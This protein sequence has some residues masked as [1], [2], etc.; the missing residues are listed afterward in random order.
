MK[1]I[2]RKS[3]AAVIVI[4]VAGGPVLASDALDW[5]PAKT[6][7]FAVGL[8]QWERTD[9]WSPFP[10]AMIDRR[11]EQLVA[12]F[13]DAGVDHE[14]IS[15][16]QDAEAAKSRIE[17][18]FIELLDETDEDDLLV[19]YFCGHGYRDRETGSTWFACY[20]AADKSSSGWSVRRIFSTIEAHFNGRRVLLLADCCHSGALYDEARRRGPDSDIAYAVLTSSYAHNTST[21]NWTFSDCVLAGLRGEGQVDLDGDETVDLQEI[22]RYGELEL[23]F[24]EGQKSMFHA[25]A[26]FPR[27]ARLAEV[28]EAATPRVGQRIE[29]EYQGKWYR[30]KTIDADG[31]QLQVHYVDFAD[32][33]DEWLGPERVRPYRPAQFAEGDKVDVQWEQDDQWYPATVVRGWYGLHRVRYDGYDATSD[34]WVGPARIRLRSE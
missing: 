22:A 19:F 4:I 34:E 24:V 27:R 21:G 31:E 32:S 13:R 11:D 28:S 14:R 5:D 6:W 2:W 29:A 10:D 23:A 33:W 18:A 1:R 25:S 30:A 15:Y 17:E 26:E 12:F 3:L 16:L 7:V 20:D 9:L 8:L